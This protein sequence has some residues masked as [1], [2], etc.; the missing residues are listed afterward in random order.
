[1]TNHESLVSQAALAPL[2]EP[3]VSF[4]ATSNFTI[5]SYNVNGIRA[6]HKNLKGGFEKF[7]D[8]N[9]ADVYC[10][11]ELKCEPDEIPFPVPLGYTSVVNSCPVQKGYSGT[12]IL[13]KSKPLST[14]IGLPEVVSFF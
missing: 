9:P 8:A 4:S 7:F 12:M 13:S 3:V 6:A 2:P 11:Q 10:F 5:L 1:M 14:V